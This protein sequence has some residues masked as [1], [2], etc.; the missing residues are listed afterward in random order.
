MA[1]LDRFSH[2]LTGEQQESQAWAVCDSCGEDIYESAYEVE[3]QYCCENETCLAKL[4]GAN[5]K[6]A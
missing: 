4:V 1:N 2:A 6:T 5:R 3:G